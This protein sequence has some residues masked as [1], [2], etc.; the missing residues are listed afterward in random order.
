M[1]AAQPAAH[2][3]AFF[4]PDSATFSYVVRD[5]GS[6]HCAIVDPVLNFDYAS[7]SLS[8]ENANEIAD[9]VRRNQLTVD[10]IIE[11]HVHA[12]HLSAASYLKEQVGGRL[13]I[14]E[15][16]VTVQEVFAG[17]YNEGESF[18]RDGS[19]FDHLF[20]DQ[21][22]YQI[23]ELQCR[24]LHTPGHTPA[25]MTH[26]LG[27]AAF[28]GDTLFMP[29]MGTARADFPGGDASQLWDS[30]QKI[31]ALP[32]NTRLYMCHDY[33]GDSRELEYESSISEQRENNIHLGL[34]QTR[35][36]YVA[37]REARDKTLDMPHLILPSLQ[38]NIRAGHLPAADSNGKVFLRIPVN[39]FS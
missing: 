25:C 35:E 39:A 33:P 27:D 13:G 30:I 26:V 9:Y 10:W 16:V 37:M 22:S 11:T 34:E 19:Q 4:E 8:H 20:K 2:V 5:P 21:E 23:G 18:P 36:G 14:G 17:V 38:V 12:D 24:A 32:E 7:G 29:D 6:Q 31:L 28:V 1:N 15:H 3:A